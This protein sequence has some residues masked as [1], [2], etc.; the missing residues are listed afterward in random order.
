MES[1]KLG[2]EV[3]QDPGAVEVPAATAGQ[4]SVAD[5]RVEASVVAAVIAGWPAL[6]QKATREVVDKYGLP[7]EATAS[8]LMWFH[9]KPWKRIIVYRDEVPHN[10]PQPHSDVLEQVIDYHVPL[11]KVADLARFDGSIIVERTKGE[12]SARCDMEAANV[13]AFNLMH[14]IVTGGL[15][16]DEAR[17]LYA[18]ETARYLLNRPA[19]YAEALQFHVVHESMVD[20]DESLLALVELEQAAKEMTDSFRRGNS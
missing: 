8:R 1:K 2:S 4:G 6:P 15:S 5:A 17:E 3:K 18:E 14:K 13:L 7:N 19:P 10:F 20:P 12:V 16:A 9:C 11:E